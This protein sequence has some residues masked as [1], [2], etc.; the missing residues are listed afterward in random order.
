SI[1]VQNLFRFRPVDDEILK[2][3]PRNAELYFLHLLGSYFKGNSARIIDKYPV[4]F[5]R[6]IKRNVLVSL[7]G[8]CAAIL[9]PN[10]H[11]LAVLHEGGKALSKP[12]YPFAYRKIQ[13]F[14]HIYRAAVLL[15]MSHGLE[16][17]A[18]NA[19]RAAVEINGPL[20]P[21]VYSNA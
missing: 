18:R 3:F 7:L 19:L 14:T 21:L 6:N 10:I 9:V 8:A 12:V 11:N 1:F 17:A 15:D 5:V 2:R 16:R 13:F 4:S 20:R